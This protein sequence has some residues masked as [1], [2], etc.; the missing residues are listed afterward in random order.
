MPLQK[1]ELRPGVNRES[2]TYSNEGGFF[3][4]DKIRFRSGYAEK[5]GGWINQSTFSFNGAC[6]SLFNWITFDNEN[7]LGV[8]TNSKMYVEN[9][10]IYHD[11]TPLAQTVTLPNNPFAT[12][13]GSYLVTVTT[14]LPHN[15]SV[16]TYVTF[17]GVSGGGIVNGV[18]LNGNFEVLTVPTSTTFTILG[19]V[20]ATSTGTGGGA[21]VSAAIEINAG[22][23]TFSLGLGWGG[24]PWG[25]GGWGVGS[26]ISAQIR[27]WSQDNDNENLL[28][29]PRSGPIYYWDKDT[30]FW[31]RAITLNAY[32]N[33]QVKA[34]TQVNFAS[35]DTEITVIDP[36]GIDTGSV[37]SGTGIPA[38]TYVTTAYIAG[39]Y[40]V[41][42]SAATTAPSSGTYT[43]SYAGRHV[44]N[45]TYQVATS[46][47][48]NFT[49]AFGS[50][51]YSPVN[52]TEA[53]DPLLIRWSDADNPF[54]WVPATTNQSGETRLSYGSYIV[55]ALDTRQEILIWTDA[56]IFS[57]QY[58]GP[59]YVYG[60]N[61]LLE[62]I[63]IASPNSAITINN[64]TYWM[65]VDK[66]YQYSGR[67]ET[68]PCSLRQFVFTNINTD[69]L[70]QIV[71]GS[72]EGYNEVWWFYPTAD[73]LVNNRYVV[74][75][76]LERIWY[77]GDL[78]RSFWLDSPLRQY[79][80]AA[81][82]YQKSYLSDAI[83]SSVTILP[84]VNA[85]SYPNEGVVTIDSEKILYTGKTSNS[86]T[87]CTRGYDGTM[88]ASHIQYSTVTYN[89]PNQVMN[90]ENG[91]DDRSTAEILPIAAYI[92]TSDFDIGDGHNFGYVWRI[93]P[94]LT[95]NGSNSNTPSATITVKARQN[96]GTAYTQGDNP[97]V[98][99]TQSIPIE[100]Y[101]GQVYTRIRGRQ[102]AF[103]LASTDIGVA[104]Q[105]GM[106][107][108]D[109][110]PDGRR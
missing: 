10:G 20:V 33:T 21:A 87:G 85:A 32:A 84:M 73:S 98:Q 11:I 83:N 71:C 24:G 70:A 48:G 23:A 74:Y 22:N 3:S 6:R 60:V 38:G 107:R 100:L 37:V 2:T 42:I 19:A 88:A 26:A 59:P 49:I 31:S 110:R 41:P 105:M 66:F 5:I 55:A 86:L 14:T 50:N 43:F 97:T 91:N 69:Q 95:F 63:S 76:H 15:I 25:F 9:A 56:A 93:L 45:N 51:P 102:M 12:T 101:T 4:C 75:N 40:T 81:F 28:F 8:G 82:S 109:I 94:D 68:L 104:W 29:N 1:L 72:N 53:F 77:Y 30:A 96:S 78:E 57:M 52:F 90:H 106:M 16:G 103:R 17:S 54:E 18:T 62:N 7:L 46:S 79:P 92:E 64:V 27:L 80:M 36:N 108:L 61:L 99:E 34:A 44:P 47:V 35:G 13:N 39:S 65:G 58:L 67:V 89:V